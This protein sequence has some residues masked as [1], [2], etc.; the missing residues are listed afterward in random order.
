M[1]GGRTPSS[2]H[3]FVPKLVT[4][5]REGYG[6]GDARADL[7]AGVTV[8]VVALPLSLALAIASGTSPGRGLF[9]AVV[10]GVVVSALGGSRYQIAG[11]TGAFVV[12]VAGIVQKFGYDG[13]V[14]A[15]L[16]AGL[17]LIATGVARLG[18]YIK[19]VPFPVVT[20]FTAGIAVVIFSSQVGDILGLKL[21]G[22][23]IDA[24]SRLAADLAAIGT[25]NPLALAVA[26]GTL[27][28][29]L[30]VQNFA[31]RIPA[32]LVAIALA[33]LA[34]WALKLPVATIGTRFGGIPASL[35]AAHLPAI[36]FGEL[37]ILFP[38]AFTIFA[39][40]GI[41]SLLSAVVA[42]GMTGRR[43]RANCELVAQ[44]LA[45]IASAV[46]GGIPAT[47]A[48]AR[49]A[50]N[51]RAGARTPIAGIVHSAAILATMAL[52]SPLASYIPLAALAGVLVVVC[53]NMAELRVFGLILRSSPGDRAVLILT[54]LLTIFVDLSF[55]I[56]AGIVLAS[57]VFAYNM[58]NTA[59]AK[60]FL[61]SVSDDVDEFVV[62]NRDAFPRAQLPAG[63][64]VFR[65]SGPFFFAAAAEFEDVLSRSGGSPKVLI[66]RMA[67]VPMIDTTGAASL[68][69]FIR[70]AKQRG[71][72]I[73]LSEVN[74]ESALA[75]E[76]MD[77]VVPGAGS[78]AGSVAL[79][80]G[81]L[82]HSNSKAHQP[83]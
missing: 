21:H 70:S 31:P 52:F 49:T 42:D 66:L 56:A 72:A 33:A 82:Q 8:A 4:S 65:L 80:E 37:R 35:P 12:V 23:P 17:L 22:A 3:L 57:L 38:S 59:E 19:Y 71:T 6:A 75:L 54:F 40:G 27:G 34:V 24:V 79:A 68:K 63:I 2:W 81:L 61:P 45:N 29:I 36:S 7:F 28:A 20:G 64:E 50:T 53:W 51:I 48:I 32:F 9:T 73:V 74:A 78:F 83:A 67:G 30:L 76:N 13:L 41:E 26:A 77:I 62:P 46:M 69:R 25:F 16:M 11:P 14:V 1:T 44:G 43:H 55:A 18:S 5:L 10:A 58:A 60:R 15:M 47:G 39:L